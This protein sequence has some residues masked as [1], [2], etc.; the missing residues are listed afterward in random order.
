MLTTQ[1]F[2]HQ[3][4]LVAPHEEVPEREPTETSLEE[5]KRHDFMA[6]VAERYPPPSFSYD[7]VHG[8]YILARWIHGD[9]RRRTGEPEF[10][11]ARGV[12]LILLEEFNVTN[13]WVVSSG[14]LHD[15]I[16]VSGEVEKNL[17]ENPTG[18]PQHNQ[19]VDD[20]VW[21]ANGAKRWTHELAFHMS[22]FDAPWRI[23]VVKVADRL[24]NT[25]T[26]ACYTDEEVQLKIAQTEAV[27]LPLAKKLGVGY[28]L[29]VSAIKSEKQRRGFM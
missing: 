23:A 7:V 27:Y 29:L 14:L 24:H 12:A 8:S 10:D 3:P 11:H 28:D 18:H 16:E 26:L 21:L 15:V 19:F 25:R 2:P 4:L 17:R 9:R 6:K 20:L 13:S 22:F 1:I 5:Q